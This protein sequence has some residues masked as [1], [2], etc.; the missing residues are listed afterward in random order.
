MQGTVVLHAVIGKDGRIV[1]LQFVSGNKVFEDSTV[2][3]VK[4]WRYKPF[5]VDGE[6]VE[7]DTII[8][9]NYSLS[10]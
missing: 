9:V 2:E 10:N 5:L 4:R 3:A 1:Y 7:T 6:P 8:E